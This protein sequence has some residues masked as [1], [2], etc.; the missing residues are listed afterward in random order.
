MKKENGG[1]LTYQ[2]IEKPN[3]ILVVPLLNS[4][5]ILFIKEF[6]YAIDEYQLDLPGG[7]IDQGENAIQTANRELQEE[8]GFRS[9][10]LDYLGTLTISPGY[11]KQKTEV[12]L[13]RDLIENRFPGDEE[14][15]LTVVKVP[16]TDFEKLIDEGKLTESRAIAALYMARRF[17][18]KEK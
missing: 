14:E 11:I 18:E 6:M 12:F 4:T 10:K 8:V 2:I 16:F 1:K 17:L 5:T 9:E 3:S 15:P 13:A 7:R